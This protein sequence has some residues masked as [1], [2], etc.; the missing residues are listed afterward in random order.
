MGFFFFLNFR[1]KKV[2]DPSYLG[3]EAGELIT[4]LRLTWAIEYVKGQP[5]Q[6]KSPC[7]NKTECKK[8]NQNKTKH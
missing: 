5:G 3:V 4:C 2:Y 8:P 1:L 7:L 6:L